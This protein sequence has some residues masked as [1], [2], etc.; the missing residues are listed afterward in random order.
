M[1]SGAALVTGLA[2]TAGAALASAILYAN[3]E[4]HLL[5]LRARDAAAVLSGAVP[6]IERPLAVA[7]EI[8]ARS[9][10]P[11]AAFSSVVAPNVGVPG[12][13][14]HTFVS[15]SLYHLGPSAPARLVTLG[16]PGTPRDPAALFATARRD[17][18]IAVT[19]ILGPKNKRRI[20]YG[21][22]AAGGRY[23]A[24]AESALPAKRR[25]TLQAGSPFSGLDFALYEGRLPRSAELVE[26]NVAPLPVPAPAAT[27]TL[28]FGSSELLLV[29]HSPSPLAGALF[30]N[31]Q[32]ITAGL[33]TLLSL[34][35][36]LLLERLVRRREAAAANADRLS[37][38]QA[39]AI[40][41]GGAMFHDDVEAA[42]TELAVP[43][44]G[45]IAGALVLRRGDQ[46]VRTAIT[47][48]PPDLLE[49]ESV[50][51]DSPLALPSAVR[52]GTIV[53]APDARAL[54]DELG[55]PALGRASYAALPLWAQGRCIGALGLGFAR[56]QSFD[57]AQVAFFESLARHLASALE[58][59]GLHEE[60][61]HLLADRTEIAE[62]LQQ[63]LLPPR[64]PELPG[65]ALAV[66]YRPSGGSAPVGG[67]FYD[68]FSLGTGR[69]L[70]AIG[71]VEGR[72][73]AAAAVTGLVRH[74]LRALM[75]TGLAPSA[76]LGHVNRLLLAQDA[77]R[78]EGPTRFCTAAVATL[79]L[80]ETG[81]ARLTL[82]LAGHPAP[83][84]F[85]PG[86]P[87]APVGR[88]GTLLGVHEDAHFVDTTLALAAGDTLVL[89]SD[90]VTE[91]RDSA[92]RFFGEE[93]IVRSVTA[94]PQHDATA[95]AAAIESAV[96][97]FSPEE[98]ADDV[99][100]LVLSVPLA[101]DTP[102]TDTPGT[103]RPGAGD[104]GPADEELSRP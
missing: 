48:Y 84:L 73:V 85:R 18:T 59:T 78:S 27:A 49:R 99:A 57:H 23:A 94:T 42:V 6:D 58:R 8:A 45:A 11:R 92:G 50:P 43:A 61:M 21:V 104:A 53:L 80:P 64:L 60:T 14:G 62:G 74:A 56:R 37:R 91:R 1:L 28:A 36:A 35:I 31:L 34:G 15:A 44:A 79:E 13:R 67:D 76:A 9:A 83:L 63:S 40:A 70:L 88:F 68:A 77:G 10:H 100:I 90:G 5:T 93:E 17:Q 16:A 46:V 97:D 22:V 55:S 41:L 72:G 47:G 69:W 51:L 87:A 19:G 12:R 29:M 30:A 38:L 2:L 96:R 81:A 52:T 25:V 65:L 75:S 54:D 33:G 86:A 66:R 26:T 98:L 20:G 39:T 82:S 103:A 89:F 7:A 101:T 102:G 95:V 3:T 24:F 71:D 32:W 4:S